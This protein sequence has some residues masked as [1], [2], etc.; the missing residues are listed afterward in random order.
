MM[1]HWC[2]SLD[3]CISL[4]SHVL[5][6]VMGSLS[7]QG[8]ERVTQLTSGGSG[9]LLGCLVRRGL[10]SGNYVRVSLSEWAAPGAVS[11]EVWGGEGEEEEE[12]EGA[13][14]EEDGWRG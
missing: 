7:R 11:G 4:Q 8:R 1:S 2:L 3:W 9:R 14:Q 13:K 6:E 12:E 5:C 10:M